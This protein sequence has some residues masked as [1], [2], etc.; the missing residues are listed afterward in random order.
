MNDEYYQDVEFQ[1]Q[2][3]PFP[4]ETSKLKPIALLAIALGGFIL[5]AN[6]SESES[7]PTTLPPTTLPT[8]TTTLPTSTLPSTTLPATT[9]PSTTL[10]LPATCTTRGIFSN[11]ESGNIGTVTENPTNTFTM[12][13]GPKG[14]GKWFYIKLCNLNSTNCT[15]TLNL[16][17][18]YIDWFP[19][20][21]VKRNNIVV[22][23]DK[24][25]WTKLTGHLDQGVLPNIFTWNYTPQYN[26]EY[27]VFFIPYTNQNL[28]EFLSTYT[29]NP[30][31]NQYITVDNIGTTYYNR[32]QK[33]VTITDP[34]VSDTGKKVIWIIYREDAG[35]TIGSFNATGTIKYLL[36]PSAT[37]IIRNSIWKLCPIVSVDAVYMGASAGIS[38][39]GG[40][41]YITREWTRTDDITPKEV[42]NIKNQVRAWKDANKPIDLVGRQ[43]SW[44]FQ[45][46]ANAFGSNNTTL[47]NKAALHYT[48]TGISL[49]SGDTWFLERFP[50]FVNSLYPGVIHFTTE[51][52]MVNTTIQIAEDFGVSTLLSIADYFGI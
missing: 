34:T 20:T 25:N 39:T 13:F 9:L 4:K 42:L 27:I 16:P 10:P 21:D 30:S 51:E 41:S 22:S 2:P 36:S 37:N 48:N 6:K 11:F 24:T 44:M 19:D 18:G 46:T 40:D 32:T 1:P 31:I 50:Q 8:T 7:P 52:S 5:L 28:D 47:N 29:T 45:S 26:E 14:N 23:H 15:F 3:E 33:M 43:H 17:S 38:Y 49:I 35:E 12:N